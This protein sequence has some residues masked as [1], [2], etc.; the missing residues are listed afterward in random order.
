M[1]VKALLHDALEVPDQ[2]VGRR[3]CDFG[4]VDSTAARNDIPE[5]SAW[6]PRDVPAGEALDGWGP[7]LPPDFVENA[8]AS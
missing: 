8:G 2:T 7:P 3:D 1:P 5:H 4:L 6:E